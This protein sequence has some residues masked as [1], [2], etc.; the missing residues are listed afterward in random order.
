MKGF[1]HYLYKILLITYVILIVSPDIL[2]STIINTDRHDTW[3]K[4]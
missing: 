3:R 2:A 1:G 4:F